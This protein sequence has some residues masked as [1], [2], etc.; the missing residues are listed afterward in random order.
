MFNFPPEWSTANKGESIVGV[1]SAQ[2]IKSRRKLEVEIAMRK[3]TKDAF[4]K[5]GGKVE[6]EIL[7]DKQLKKFQ[8]D[9]TKAEFKNQPTW[10]FLTS[11]VVID[12]ISTEGDIRGFF[13]A[14]HNV[15]KSWMAKHGEYAK[16][17]VQDDSLINYRD[18]RTDG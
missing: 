15:M 11:F 8:E 16:D 18:I 3:F 12:W 10:K 13:D 17:F 14:V 9:D 1:R 2:I 4:V 5:H 6:V 7:T